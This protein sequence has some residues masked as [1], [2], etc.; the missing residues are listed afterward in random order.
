MSVTSSVAASAPTRDQLKAWLDN[1]R[2]ETVRVEWSDVHGLSRGK[3]LSRERFTTALARGLAQSTAPL[4]M[5]LQGN[6]VGAGERYQRAGWPDML[7]W[8]DLTTLRVVPYEEQAALVLADLW[9]R[10][11]DP[12]P[13]PR[14]VLKQVV[15]RAEQS[16]WLFEVGAELE[17]YLFSSGDL[18]RLPPGKQALR[19]R[20]GREEKQAVLRM[21]RALADMGFDVEACCAEDGPGQF[22]INIACSGPVPAADGAFLLRNAVKEIAGQEGLLAT[23]MPK[24]LP[25]ESGSGFHVHI[26]VDCEASGHDLG[27]RVPDGSPTAECHAFIAGQLALAREL[28]ALWLPTVNAYK[29]VLAR[30]PHGPALTWGR[31]NRTAAVRLIDTPGQRLRVEN[32]IP[33]ADANPYLAIAAALVAGIVGFQQGLEPPPPLAD[34]DGGAEAGSGALPSHL[35][36]AVDLLA[37]SQ[38]ARA[39]L[40]SDFLDAFVLLKRAEARRFAAAVT[41]WE[42]QEYL[43]YL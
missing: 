33:G 3:R 43:T 39:W 12:L 30:S 21:W 37:E 31:D 5:D 26:G 10:E 14:Q 8:P 24:P 11:G 4:F 22:E 19:T 18:E 17:F 13:A 6:V 32:R 41:D 25:D 29:R 1:H 34:P 9:D 42:R 16:G 15:Q 35:A 28:A 23:F 7:A 2:I 38:R 20:F 40:G 36:E 27:E